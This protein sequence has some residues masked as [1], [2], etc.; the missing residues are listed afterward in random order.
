MD[1][2]SNQEFF[3]AILSSNILVPYLERDP[4]LADLIKFPNHPDIHYFQT[5]SPAKEIAPTLK[6]RL[7]VLLAKNISHNLEATK[8]LVAFM[9][10]HPD[11]L[12]YNVTFNCQTQ[13]YG[14]RC[15]LIDNQMHVIC[16]M[17]GGHIPDALL[18]E[19]MK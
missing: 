8:Q 1:K 16:V 6:R 18:G 17:T 19:S 4:N 5:P 12:I 14:V 3:S 13:H 15:G 10:E 9:E 11:S 2:L 7:D